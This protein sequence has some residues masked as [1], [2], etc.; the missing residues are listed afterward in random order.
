[1][2]FFQQRLFQKLEFLGPGGTGDADDQALAVNFKRQTLF[3]QERADQFSPLF[4][5]MIERRLVA[6]GRCFE[7][8][9]NDLPEGKGLFQFVTHSIIISTQK[10]L[11]KT[12]RL[13][14]IMRL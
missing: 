11:T 3:A 5:K 8:L 4:L 1:M 2:N 14:K 10:S 9:G 7:G 12:T 13:L 6:C